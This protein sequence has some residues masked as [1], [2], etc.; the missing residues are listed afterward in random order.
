VWRIVP[1]NRLGE[2]VRPLTSQSRW[3]AFRSPVAWV[4]LVVLVANDHFLKRAGLLPGSVTGKLSDLAG[5]VVAPVLACALI[6][7]RSPASRILGFAAVV[8]PFV[9]IKTVPV[10]THLVEAL[11]RLVGLDWRLWTDPT[12]LVGLLALPFAWRLQADSAEVRAGKRA[13]RVLERL[14][15]MS[16][17]VACVA[18]SGPDPSSLHTAIGV[19]NL[20]REHIDLQVFRAKAPLACAS[21]HAPPLVA[22]DFAPDRCHELVPYAI[23]PLD[24]DFWTKTY[25]QVEPPPGVEH[26]SCDAVLLRAEGLEDTVL[27]WNN[28]AQESF[29]DSDPVPLDHPNIAY[30]NRIGD[31]L[32]IGGPAV[33]ESSAATF[34]LPPSPC[35]V[36]P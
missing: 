10:A 27:F 35:K 5:L 33:A 8:L 4:A 14:G 34:E 11:T 1:E 22:G 24:L 17:A 7:A 32:F 28:V 21:V 2:R 19:V 29:D 3:A 25:D 6:G 23:A 15:A 36:A 13:T 16:A 9:A 12:D 30:L 20:T 31:R 26:R 18:T